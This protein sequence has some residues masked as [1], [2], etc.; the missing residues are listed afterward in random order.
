VV[1]II[2]VGLLAAAS[3]VG[4][5]QQGHCVVSTA[6]TAQT[7]SAGAVLF[8]GQRVSTGPEAWAELSVVGGLRVRLSAATHLSISKEAQ[9]L[10]MPV[11][12]LWVQR[13]GASAKEVW[14]ELPGSKI[15]VPPRTSL[16]IEHTR[17]GGTFVVMRAGAA[18]V[19]EG[20]QQYAL[21]AGRAWRRAFGDV[22]RGGSQRGGAALGDLVAEEAR[23]ALGDPSGLQDFL[24]SYIRGP[25]NFSFALY[26]QVWGAA[27][28]MGSDEGTTGALVEA[29]LRPPPFF[30]EEVPTKG[31]NLEVRVLFP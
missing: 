18:V 11:G 2:F 23:V 30:E 24:H 26:G 28:V 1:S 22:Q 14:V 5:I 12:R 20:D 16:V 10:E 21:Q 27:E 31:P 25:D 6:S 9:T 29:G 4:V 3:P 19:H 8:E 13:D 17:S 15:E 7:K